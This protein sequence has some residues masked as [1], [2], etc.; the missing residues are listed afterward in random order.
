MECQ[1]RSNRITVHLS[2]A[3]NLKNTHKKKGSSTGK[4]H[5]GG[6]K[7]TATRKVYAENKEDCTDRCI[8][9][10]IGEG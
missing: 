10:Q 9:K 3:I 8:G 2:T 1:R 7:P 4:S 5:Q 6:Q